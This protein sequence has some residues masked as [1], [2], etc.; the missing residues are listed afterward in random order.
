MG[1]EWTFLPSPNSRSLLGCASVNAQPQTHLPA[2]KPAICP[3]WASRS[4]T[5]PHPSTTTNSGLHRFYWPYS[6]WLWILTEW[7]PP[8]ACTN[9][10]LPSCY[11]V[12]YVLWSP[13]YPLAAPWRRK[14]QET[15]LLSPSAH[16]GWEC[17]SWFPCGGCLDHKQRL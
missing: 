2:G 3:L 5:I 7:V 6:V 16:V 8:K 14:C 15:S 4:T 12:M 10:K 9:W 11:K 13:P 1:C 17:L